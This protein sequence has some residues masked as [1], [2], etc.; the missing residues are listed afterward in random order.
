[1]EQGKDS[2][3]ER[4]KDQCTDRNHVY[5]SMIDQTAGYKTSRTNP[6]RHKNEEVTGIRHIDLFTVQHH[7]R[8]NH[9]IRYGA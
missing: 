6:N 5:L 9:S 4:Q 7:K 1:M 2:E 8:N 3:R